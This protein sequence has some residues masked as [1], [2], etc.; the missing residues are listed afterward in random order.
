[1]NGQ[2]GRAARLKLRMAPTVL[3]PLHPNPVS[4]KGVL[5]SAWHD[6]VHMVV[7]GLGARGLGGGKVAA[8]EVCTAPQFPCEPAADGD[9]IGASFAGSAAIPAQCN[10]PSISAPE[11]ARRRGGLPKRMGITLKRLF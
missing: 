4:Y 7:V 9:A 2:L 10:R 3:Q 6:W 8:S 11:P 5:A 1:M